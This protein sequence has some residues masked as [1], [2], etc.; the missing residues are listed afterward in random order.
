MKRVVLISCGKQKAAVALPARELYTS[1]LFKMS[2]AWARKQHPDD[3]FILSAKHGLIPLDKVV[4][5]YEYKLTPQTQSSWGKMVLNSLQSLY[6]LRHTEVIFL[7]GK[8]YTEP[9]VPH[10][11]YFKEP[12]AGLGLGKRLAF[13]KSQL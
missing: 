12:L 5:P 11:L 9:L 10:L 1:P 2:L 6:D 8:L 7:A 4:A 3:I 13:L